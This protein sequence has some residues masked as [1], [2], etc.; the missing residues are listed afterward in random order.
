MPAEGMDWMDRSELLTY[1]EQARVARV[2][3]DRYGFRAIRVTGGEPTLRAHLA[4]FFTMLAPLRTDLAMTTNGVRLPELAHDLAAAGLRRVNITL[5]TL[6]PDTFR[7]LTRRDELPRVLAGVDAALDAGL[8]PVKINCVV[9]RRVNDDEVVDL[10]AYGRARCVGVRFIEFMPL[11]AQGEWSMDRVVPAHEILDTI[12]AVFPLKRDSVP[13]SGHIEDTSMVGVASDAST[14][15]GRQSHPEPAERL[16]YTGGDGDVGGI[17]SVTEP[18]CG[19]CDR[20]RITADGKLRNCL[21][22]L[23]ETDLRAILRDGG[24]DDEL[25]AAI[26]GNVATK[27]AGHRIGQVTFVRP[28]RAMSQIGG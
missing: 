27:W 13:G 9:M 2:C 24:T 26:A 16:E 17:A 20:I 15:S 3:V 28:P 6:R 19:S 14:G 12:D 1:E 4:R 18:F 11:D 21:F 8:D 25:S 10:A 23:E 5:D 22:S 7:E